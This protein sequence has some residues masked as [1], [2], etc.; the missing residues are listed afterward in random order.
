MPLPA[1]T[2]A[3]PPT[4]PIPPPPH[5]RA[6]RD[7]NQ[8]TSQEVFVGPYLD[9]PA[10]KARFTQGYRDMTDAFLVRHPPLIS[11]FPP[12]HPFSWAARARKG[13]GGAGQVACARRA[14][15]S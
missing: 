14:L 10:V 15:V 3:H 2:P 1:H 4:H 7:L 11:F 5:A 12:T 9:D 6:R 8:A 13:G